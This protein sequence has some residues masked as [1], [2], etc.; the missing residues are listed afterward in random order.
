MADFPTRSVL[1]MEFELSGKICVRGQHC[2][3]GPILE[4]V[5]CPD[6]WLKVAAPYLAK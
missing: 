2:I 3:K 4:S 6:S 5:G 1:K